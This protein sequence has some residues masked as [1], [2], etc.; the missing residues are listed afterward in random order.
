[1]Q[2]PAEDDTVQRKAKPREEARAGDSPDD[3]VTGTLDLAIYETTVTSQGLGDAKELS[4]GMYL[5]IYLLVY[6]TWRRISVT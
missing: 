5:L 4:C 3:D 6:P 2:E 1:M